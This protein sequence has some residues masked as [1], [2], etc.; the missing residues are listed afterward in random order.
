MFKGCV[1]LHKLISVIVPVYNVSKYLDECVNSII[2]Q[3]YKELEIILIDDGS[4]D[5]SGVICDAFKDVDSRIIVIHQKNSGS[6]SAKNTGLKAAKGQYLAF[7]DGDDYLEPDAF[8][9]MVSHLESSNADVIQCSYKNKFINKSVNNILSPVGEFTTEEY[10]K[11]YT[12]DWTCGL[13]WDKIY[14]RKLFNGIYFEVGRVV[15]DEFFTYQGLMKAKKIVRSTHIVYNYRKR[16]SSVSY[17]PN[18]MEKIIIDK[19]DYITARREKINDS[20]PN[21]KNIFN[22]HY[23]N[24]LVWLSTDQFSSDYTLD[25]IKKFAFQYLKNEGVLNIEAK[26]LYILIKLLITSN[27]KLLKKR[28]SNDGTEKNLKDYYN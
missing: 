3:T 21:L 11:L 2:M 13:L 1:E 24:M 26:D 18:N 28:R 6:G 27:R 9:Y 12:T 19:L 20:F 15:D 23:L 22:N 25:A 5:K 14:K 17:L 4:T 7:V 16:A 10:L 8:E